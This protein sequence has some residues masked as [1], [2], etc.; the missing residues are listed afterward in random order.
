MVPTIKETPP[1]R[2]MDL[3][4]LSCLSLS[5]LLFVLVPLGHFAME[6]P[7]LSIVL[8]WWFMEDREVLKMLSR[9]S[10]TVISLAKSFFE[11]FKIAYKNFGLSFILLLFT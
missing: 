8:G 1:A 11:V 10:L 6:V 7:M 5:M 3:G 4:M 2:P 9:Q